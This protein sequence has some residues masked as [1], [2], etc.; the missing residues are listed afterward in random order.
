MVEE[1]AASLVVIG[2]RRKPPIG[3]LNLGASARRVVLGAPCPVLAVK[4]DPPHRGRAQHLLLNR[5]NKPLARALYSTGL[6]APCV[7]AP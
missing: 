4:D 3:K 6:T 1:V 2:L 5:G 7:R